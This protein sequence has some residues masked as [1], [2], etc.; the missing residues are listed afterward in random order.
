MR[1][2]DGRICRQRELANSLTERLRGIEQV[3]LPIEPDWATHTYQSYVIRVAEGVDRDELI[4]DLRAHGIETTLG[5]YAL[6]AQ[7]FF[8]KEYG[9]RPGD[10]PNSYRAYRQSLTLPVHCAVQEH[11]LDR[12]AETLCSAL[13]CPR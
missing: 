8:A 6:H 1:K 4:R 3:A 9:L 5:T 10:I 13:G 2:L 7:P 11:D 12:I